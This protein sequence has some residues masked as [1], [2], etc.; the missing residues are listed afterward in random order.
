[1]KRFFGSRKAASNLPEPF[2]RQL[3]MYAL[4]AGAAGVGVLP[5]TQRAEA[6]IVYTPANIKITEN[7]GLI[8]FDLNHDGIPDFGL[9]NK[10][11]HT[12]TQWYG[13]LAVVQARKANEIWGVQSK[14]LLCAGALPKGIRVG[15]KGRF[16]EDPTTGLVMAFSNPDTYFGRWFHVK[17]AY[18]GLKFVIKG[19]THFGWARVKLNVKGQITATL[20]GYAYETIPNKPIVTGE[21]RST[22]GTSKDEQPNPAALAAPIAKPDR[23]GLLALGS[24]GLSIWRRKESVVVTPEN[25]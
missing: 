1:M 20:T 22:D 15:P 7:G 6:R 14:G 4:A 25:N 19:K 8:S 23:L 24:S 2:H 3:N 13:T 10:Y 9:S 18:L 16:Q 12:Q 11:L 21:T 17:Q 5:L